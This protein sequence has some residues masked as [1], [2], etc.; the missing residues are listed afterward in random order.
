MWRVP[1]LYLTLKSLLANKRFLG[2]A[3]WAQLARRKRGAFAPALAPP[4]AWRLPGA[5]AEDWI[6]LSAA[7]CANVL[8]NQGGNKVNLSREEV[9]CTQIS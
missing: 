9:R 1:N 4:P 5:H 6:S 3:Y 7:F 2:R 8:E